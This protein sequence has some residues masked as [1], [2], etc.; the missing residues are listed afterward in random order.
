MVLALSGLTGTIPSAI[1]DLTCA[2]QLTRMYAASRAS[3]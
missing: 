2:S 3:G 1:A